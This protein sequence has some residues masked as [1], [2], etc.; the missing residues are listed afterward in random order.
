MTQH[1]H[2]R[3]PAEPALLAAGAIGFWLFVVG[4]CVAVLPDH[5]ASLDQPE[6][7][8]RVAD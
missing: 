3:K 8:A 1:S 7:M 2:R 4:A 5:V 6:R